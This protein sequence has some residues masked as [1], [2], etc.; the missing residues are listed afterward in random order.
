MFA[1]DRQSA[2][3]SKSVR[4]TILS[5]VTRVK[6]G[7]VM[8][9]K[10]EVETVMFDDVVM[11]VGAIVGW[12]Q[13]AGWTADDS[14]V[15]EVAEVEAAEV[16]AVEV[17]V[18][19]IKVVEAEEIEVEAVEV[20]A[21]EVEAVEV[22]AAEREGVELG[23][24]IAVVDSVG[25][26]SVASLAPTNRVRVSGGLA[27]NF[28]FAIDITGTFPLSLSFLSLLPLLF[29]LVLHDIFKNLL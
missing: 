7:M 6:V 26:Q 25:F 12:T 1:I 3:L 17:G 4:S 8:S 9:R 23:V 16:K 24:V 14:K 5:T 21:V 2:K 20:N 18:V 27:V 22:D 10:D 11:G 19:K 29:L 28:F 13:D 15:V